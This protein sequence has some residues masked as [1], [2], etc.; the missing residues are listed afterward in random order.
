MRVRKCSRIFIFLRRPSSST[1]RSPNRSS[2]APPKKPAVRPIDAPFSGPA[3]TFTS[4]KPQEGER[5]FRMNPSTSSRVVE[6]AGGEATHLLGNVQARG[7]LYESEARAGRDDANGGAWRPEADFDFGAHADELHVGLDAG[8]ELVLHDLA[9]VTAGV[10]TD[11]P[12]DY[13]SR[14]RERCQSGFSGALAT[15]RY[16]AGASVRSRIPLTWW[17][18]WEKRRRFPCANTGEEGKRSR[19]DFKRQR[20]RRYA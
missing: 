18:C 4:V 13:D 17:K 8:D 6:E 16:S 9:V 1:A 3:Y 19:A 5:F 15:R 7:G 20:K 12:A 11:A 2:T 10:E 14:F